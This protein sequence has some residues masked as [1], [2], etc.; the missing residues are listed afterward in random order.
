MGPTVKRTENDLQPFSD[1]VM[2]A[3]PFLQDEDQDR[4]TTKTTRPFVSSCRCALRHHTGLSNRLKRLSAA[5]WQ[6]S[7]TVSPA[8]T[9]STCPLERPYW[10]RCRVTSRHS[11][12][13]RNP[14]ARRRRKKRKISQS[15]YRATFAMRRA[16]LGPWTAFPS[17]PRL[18]TTA[19]HT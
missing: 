5:N 6:S 1:G 10:N 8:S 19:V 17:A 2:Q 18:H 3:R 13:T 16:A 12:P 9:S 15:I 14:R 11:R 4:R 7:R